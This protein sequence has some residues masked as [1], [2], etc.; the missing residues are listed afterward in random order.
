MRDSIFVLLLSLMVYGCGGES[1]APEEI[2]HSILGTWTGATAT[3]ILVEIQMTDETTGGCSRAATGNG[4]IVTTENDTLHAT[5]SG[6]N[7]TDQVYVNFGGAGN[8]MFGQFSGQFADANTLEGVMIG[9]EAFGN[10][11][12]GPFRADSAS[13]QLHRE[14]V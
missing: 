11:P 8:P 6:L 5:L 2:Q 3:R 12:A 9:P 13:I 4:R 10:P 7:Q 14:G 1:A